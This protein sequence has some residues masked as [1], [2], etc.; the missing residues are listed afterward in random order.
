MDFSNGLF[1][2][3]FPRLSVMSLQHFIEVTTSVTV[4]CFFIIFNFYLITFLLLKAAAMWKSHRQARHCP[5]CG[6]AE[7]S[8]PWSEGRTSLME[9]GTP[10]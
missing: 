8:G 2:S 5:V 10:C 7:V 9:Q 6:T 4:Y 3:F 1:F